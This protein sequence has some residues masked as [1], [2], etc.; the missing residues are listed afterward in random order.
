MKLQSLLPRDYETRFDNSDYIILG[1]SLFLGGVG[2]VAM[3]DMMGNLGDKKGQVL[4]G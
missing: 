1:S 3:F 2:L 4:T